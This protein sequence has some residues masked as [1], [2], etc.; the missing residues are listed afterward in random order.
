MRILLFQQQDR[1]IFVV[2]EHRYA[3]YCWK[4]ALEQNLIQK[5]TFL[6]H[7]D[8]HTDFTLKEHH[9]QESEAFLTLDD[10]QAA[11]FI[12]NSLDQDNS[13]FIVPGMLANIVKDG[14]AVYRN[15]GLDYGT[16]TQSTRSFPGHTLH[17]YRSESL[18]SLSFYLAEHP[19]PEDYILDIDLDYFTYKCEAIYPKHPE[20]LMLQLQSLKPLWDKAKII[21]IALEPECCGGKTHCKEILNAV[22]SFLCH[23]ILEAEKLI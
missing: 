1:K 6:L 9:K 16:R 5:S 12:K 13:E 14:L 17:L 7:I 8:A 4:K 23:G 11:D 15:E 10:K 2:R 3:L 19:I 18:S 20:D 21:T 22:D